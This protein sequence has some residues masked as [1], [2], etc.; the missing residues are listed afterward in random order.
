[1]RRIEREVHEEWLALLGGF[2]IDDPLFGAGGEEIGGVALVE[3]GGD[4]GAIVPD[5][6]RAAVDAFLGIM[7]VTVAVA[8]VAEVFVEAALERMGGPIGRLRG[9]LAL[10]APLADRGGGVARL[11]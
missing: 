1:M 6:L 5:F 11:F 10:Q 3:A 4:F 2:V 9:G 7:L 8:D